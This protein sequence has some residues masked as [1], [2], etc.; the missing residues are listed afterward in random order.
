MML[1][2]TWVEDSFHFLSLLAVFISFRILIVGIFV[3]LWLAICSFLDYNFTTFH[4][5]SGRIGIAPSDIPRVMRW[6]NSRNGLNDIDCASGWVNSK[7]EAV[8]NFKFQILK[9][10][11]KAEMSV[12]LETK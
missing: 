7:N 3:C 11:K 1:L 6:E 12:Q 8:S 2:H 5:W 9:K 4:M 10:K